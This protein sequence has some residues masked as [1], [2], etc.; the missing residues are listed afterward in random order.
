V[1]AE[2]QEEVEQV[3]VDLASFG[4]GTSYAGRRFLMTDAHQIPLQATDLQ[5]LIV[6]PR[7][8]G[9]EIQFGVAAKIEVL[10][11]PDRWLTVILRARK[12]PMARRF[13]RIPS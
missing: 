8:G 11:W 3:L 4:I 9:A 2:R 1:G 10:T 13:L 6:M 5:A 7:D 12:E